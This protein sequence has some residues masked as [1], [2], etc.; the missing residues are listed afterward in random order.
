MSPAKKS[1]P[2]CTEVVCSTSVGGK[3]QV[4]K[5]EYSADFHYSISRKYDIPEGWSEQDVHDFQ[6]E[7]E[8][9]LR[10]TLEGLA[11][12]EVEELMQQRDELKGS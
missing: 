11:S 12:S 4:V 6:V 9:Q 3:V 2:K 5:F 8:I 1:E 7:K 10:G